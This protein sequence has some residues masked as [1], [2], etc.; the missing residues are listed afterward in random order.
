MSF[1]TIKNK[2]GGIAALAVI[3]GA[4][5]K[6]VRNWG[7]AKVQR[8]CGGVIPERYRAAILA[9]VDGLTYADFAVKE[10][11]AMQSRGPLSASVCEVA[12]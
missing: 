2:A 5:E 9:G 12:S 3:V 8:G 11:S 1:E 7:R 6:T 4:P 10:E